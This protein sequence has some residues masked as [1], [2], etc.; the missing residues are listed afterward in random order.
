MKRFFALFAA[1]TLLCT[2]ISAQTAACR[3]ETGIAYRD[4]AGDGYVDSLCRLDICWPADRKGFPTVVWFHGG[5]LTGGRR[6]IP[7]ALCG[8]GFAVVGVDYRLA[9]RVKVADC[10]ADAA[11]AAAWVVKNI[12]SYGGDPAADLHRRT[13]GGR[14]P[15]FDDRA[16]QTLD[17]A[18]RHRPRHGVRGAD[19]LQRAGS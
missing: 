10:V 8:K 11:A 7:K 16:G 4:A 13:F 2:G 5:G 15:D 17:G 14:L 19:P 1:L 3:T 9:P 18:L 6:E 12:A